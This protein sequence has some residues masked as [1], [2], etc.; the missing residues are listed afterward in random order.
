MQTNVPPIRF[1]DQGAV[2]PAESAILAG[3]QADI[4]AAFGGGVNP[5]L[6]TPQGQIAQSLTAIIG[7]ANGDILEVANQVDPDVASGRW[8]DA[9]GRIYFLNRIAASGTVVTATCTGLVGAVIPAGSVAQ[10]VNG[11]LYASTTAA[12]IPASGQVEVPFQCQTKGPVACPIG[13]LA[14]IYTAVQGWDRVP[15]ATAGTPGQNVET[16]AQFEARRRLSVAINAVNSVQAVYAA[17]LS[18]ANVLDAFVIDNPTG[19]TVNYGATDYPL[20]PHS[21]FLS[22]IGGDASPIAQAIWS[23]KAPG[24]DYNGDTSWIVDDTSYNAPQPQYTVTWVTPAPVQCCFTVTI[25]ANDQSPASIT[26]LIQRAILAA[27]N[28]EDGGVKARIG[29]TTY[30]G[31]YYAGV[32]ATHP[33]VNIYSIA[34]AFGIDQY[35]TLDPSN[36]SVLQLSQDMRS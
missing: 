8:Q 2:L 35:P 21:V 14:T 17:V 26:S 19:A 5:G 31:R 22:A 29:S 15:N 34:L 13:A 32:A 6:T 7:D 20:L 24:C 25:Q 33:N 28:G 23:K 27:F 9:I 3:V 11:Y 36:V 4:N 10:D 16:R 18:V 1:T 12:V 30:P